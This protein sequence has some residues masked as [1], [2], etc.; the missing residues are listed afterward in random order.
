MSITTPT[1][2]LTIILQGKSS[3][4]IGEE[5]DSEK[6]GNLSQVIEIISG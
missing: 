6:L 4:V 3:D 1:L 5:R 2:N